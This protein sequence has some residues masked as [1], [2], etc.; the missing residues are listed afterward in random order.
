LN[1]RRHFNRR[2]AA[3]ADASIATAPARTATE[4]AKGAGVA[5]QGKLPI[6]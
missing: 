2:T 6:S 3:G 4:M 1:T 5:K